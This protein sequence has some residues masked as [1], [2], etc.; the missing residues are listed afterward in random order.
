MD[1]F[2]LIM[3]SE[4]SVI[5][6]GDTCVDCRMRRVFA[7]VAKEFIERGDTGPGSLA[8]CS[9]EFSRRMKT[10]PCMN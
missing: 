4:E 9:E 10:E 2:F 3:L 8:R 5:Q 7:K 1:E 6:H